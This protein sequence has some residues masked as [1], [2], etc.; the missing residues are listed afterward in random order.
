MSELWPAP[1][2][3]DR[4]CGVLR[5][6]QGPGLELCW[7][8][9]G[10][11]GNVRMALGSPYRR[12]SEERGLGVRVISPG[13]PPACSRLCRAL[14]SPEV[15]GLKPEEWGQDVLRVEPRN[16]VRLSRVRGAEATWEGTAEE[17]HGKDLGDHRIQGFSSLSKH[18][19]PRV[20]DPVRLS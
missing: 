10:V 12:S 8:L 5:M 20:S 9:L 15:S 4:P 2:S 17:R 16:Q 18:R 14:R 19:R 1:R 11:P 3:P 7:M 13:L 6:S